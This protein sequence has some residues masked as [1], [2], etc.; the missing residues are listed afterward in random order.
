MKNN[1]QETS[2]TSE[3]SA[4]ESYCK[5][6]NLLKIMLKYCSSNDLLSFSSSCSDFCEAAQEEIANVFQAKCNRLLTPYLE[7]YTYVIY[8]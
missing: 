8:I 7:G 4:I 5:N 6:K 3:I 1:V 2:E